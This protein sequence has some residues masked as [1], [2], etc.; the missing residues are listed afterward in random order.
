MVKLTGALVC[1]KPAKQQALKNM[2]QQDL[3][4]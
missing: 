4:N 2:I 3:Y 1:A